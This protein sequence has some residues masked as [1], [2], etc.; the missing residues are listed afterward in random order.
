M[1]K[2]DNEQD[3]KYDQQQQQQQQ[4]MRGAPHQYAAGDTYDEANIRMRQFQQQQQQQQRMQHMQKVNSHKQAYPNSISSP[5]SPIPETYPRSP[6]ASANL[7]NMS[8]NEHVNTSTNAPSSPSFSTS[9]ISHFTS[10][11]SNLATCGNNLAQEEDDD[12]TCISNVME[13]LINVAES[14]VASKSSTGSEFGDEK[15]TL[16]QEELQQDLSMCL[17]LYV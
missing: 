6:R 17:W 1:F 8:T 2:R 11:V 3:E 7:Q 16:H 13:G 12:T 5:L 9:L 14:V 10:G 15:D 4:K